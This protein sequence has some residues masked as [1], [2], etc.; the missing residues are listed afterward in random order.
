MI[1]IKNVSFSYESGKKS[2]DDISLHIKQGEFVVLCGR[3][4]CG[5]TTVTR[6]M[7]GLIPH[8]H[9]GEFSGEVLVQ[10]KDVSKLE[11]SDLSAICGSMFQNPKS[12]FFNIDTT[13]E[14]AFGCENLA[15]SHEEINKRI[16]KT[17]DDMELFKLMDRNIFE[18]SGGEKQQ[19]AMGSIYAATPEIY[20]LDE[21]SS[22]MDAN[23]IERLRKILVTLKEQGKTIVVSEHRLYF[24]MDLADRFLY[25][26]EGKLEKE[27]SPEEFKGLENTKLHSFGLRHTK[28]E[29]VT[30]SEFTFKEQKRGLKIDNLN[31]FRGEDR[32]LSLRDLSF[33]ENAVVA[34]IGENGAGK[35]TFID[36]VSG[37]LPSRSEIYLGDRSMNENDRVNK[38]FVVMQDVNRQLFCPSVKEE[39]ELKSNK[40]EEEIQKLMEIL[41]IDALSERHPASLSGGQKQRVAI[42]SALASNT[43]IM[44]YDEPTS[45]LDYRGMESFCHLVKENKENHKITF[46]VTHD[47]ELILGSCTHVLHLEK[48]QHIETFSLDENGKERLTDFFIKRKSKRNTINGLQRK[49]Q[50]LLKSLL[51]YSGKYK[52]LMYLGLALSGISA[53][54]FSVLG[55][56]IYG[57]GLICTHIV[58]FRVARNMKPRAVGKLMKLPLGY[59]NQTGS[60]KIRRT[61]SET[62]GKTEGYLAH[63]MPDMIGAVVTPIAVLFVFY[64]DLWIDDEI[65]VGFAKYTN[66]SR[67]S[68]QNGGTAKRKNFGL[69]KTKQHS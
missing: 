3:S 40:S 14:L 44:F 69:Q 58:A 9:E 41:D 26:K 36:C 25:F 45:G 22:N 35:S 2:I 67:C 50:S 23:S 48:G 61:L 34:I 43:E 49:K 54:I 65:D 31:C 7:N 27:Y 13:S 63:Q 19:I 51:T 46:V 66:G 32:V 11:L 5:K 8:F 64:S 62:I 56:F 33:K 38:S 17:A 37:F 1:E 28:L 55:I 60:G 68:G 16:E 42:C 52:P 18:I 10:G 15:L 59:F 47:L 30:S 20:I 12:Q 57:C 24:L 53:V 29:S 21:P 39:I 6:L 4:G